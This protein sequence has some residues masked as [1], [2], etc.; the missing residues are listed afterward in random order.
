MAGHN[1]SHQAEAEV[2]TPVARLLLVALITFATLFTA[3]VLLPS[4]PYVRYQQLAKTLHFRTVWTY[5]RIVFDRTPIDVALIG[6]SRLG[7]GVSAPALSESLSAKLGRKVNV[8][9]FS[10]PQDGRNS[11]YVLTKLL[12]ENHPEVRLVVLDI[13]EQSARKGHPAFKNIADVAD[14]IGAPILV[15]LNMVDDFAYLPYRQLTTAIATAFPR[16][17]GASRSLDVSQYAG[18]ALETTTSFTRVDGVYVD[19][20]TIQSFETID[21]SSA[22]YRDGMT[23]PVLPQSFGAYEFVMPWR[24]T[25]K[26]AALANDNGAEVAFLYLP[27]FRLKPNQKDWSFYQKVGPILDAGFLHEN[28]K[29]YS[30]GGHLNRA[31]AAIVTPWLADKLASFPILQGPT[32]PIA[33]RAKDDQAS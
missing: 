32:K 9:N 24:Y 4:D 27:V 8:V 3:S 6:N 17:S 10:M 25:S 15:N 7:T 14:L 31:G 2:P 29:V 5:E 33:T 1:L 11:H 18:P 21:K 12:L 26:I 16:L 23:P 13:I 22:I 19:R 28:F 20:D 30:D